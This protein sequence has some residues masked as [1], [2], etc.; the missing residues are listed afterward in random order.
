MGR[1]RTTTGMIAA[2]LI[3]TITIEET[4]LESEVEI[5][6]EEDGD[7]E[8]GVAG[9]AAQYLNGANSRQFS[10]GLLTPLFLH[11]HH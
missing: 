9:E 3:A 10:S 8:Q 5:D 6:E 2:S 1:G 4:N 7:L 11:G